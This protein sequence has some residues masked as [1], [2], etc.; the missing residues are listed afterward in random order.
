MRKNEGLLMMIE[1][2]LIMNGYELHIVD[3]ILYEYQPL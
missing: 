3:F 2:K 1:G